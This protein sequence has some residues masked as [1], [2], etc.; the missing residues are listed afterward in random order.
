VIEDDSLDGKNGIL[1]GSGTEIR[2]RPIT[3]LE[4]YGIA[5]PDESKRN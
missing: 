1:R 2:G 4:T 3:G 5:L